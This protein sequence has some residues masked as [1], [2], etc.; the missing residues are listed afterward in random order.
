VETGGDRPDRAKFIAVGGDLIV[1]N[2]QKPV[3]IVR[4]GLGAG[5][6]LLVVQDGHRQLR[7]AVSPELH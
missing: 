7:E 5:G 2:K 6:F 1:S 4:G 3:G